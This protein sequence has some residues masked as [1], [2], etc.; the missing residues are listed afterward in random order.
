[1]KTNN[2]K[3]F[4]NGYIWAAL[5]SLICFYSLFILSQG[6][7]DWFAFV[8]I[9]FGIV[10]TILHILFVFGLYVVAF[11]LL[12]VF[13]VK[14]NGF[15]LRALMDRYLPLVAIPFAILLSLMWMTDVLNKYATFVV[16]DIL[17]T[18]Y[19]SLYFYMKNKV[20][21]YESSRN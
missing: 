3:I 20:K 12:T 9:F 15:T 6:V 19:I 14:A 21:I 5:Y 13:D 17:F 18:C 16:F 4:F 11:P 8:F 2:F 10:M 1:M 7:L